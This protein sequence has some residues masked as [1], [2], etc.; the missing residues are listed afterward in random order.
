M[1]KRFGHRAGLAQIAAD[2]R[3]PNCIG[4]PAHPFYGLANGGSGVIVCFPAAQQIEHLLHH[5]GFA[6]GLERL[7]MQL[8]GMR[9][10][11]LATLFPRDRS[12]LVP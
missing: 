5:L 8:L 12:R 7:L 9:N 6:I 10:L 1:S 11:R 2:R 4:L 3:R